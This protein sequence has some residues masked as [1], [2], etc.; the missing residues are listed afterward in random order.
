MGSTYV[1]KW[2]L[3]G[4]VL[5]GEAPGDPRLAADAVDLAK[6]YQR[7]IKR[8]LGVTRW[9][10][11]ALGIAF[12]LLAFLH[13][14]QGDVVSAVLYTLIALGNFAHYAFNPATRPKNVA[15]SLAASEAV[16][17]AGGETAGR[18]SLDHALDPP[19]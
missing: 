18:P 1:D 10:P 6:R 16:L 4:I 15:R 5:R 3:R 9:F 12:G 8:N 11:G 2:R 7:Q 17:A 13:G 19:A 14:L